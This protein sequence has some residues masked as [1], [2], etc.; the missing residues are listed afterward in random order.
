M[1]FERIKSIQHQ[2]SESETNAILCVLP[3]CSLQGPVT[4]QIRKG[5]FD[6]YEKLVRRS[7]KFKSLEFSVIAAS[8]E[9][10]IQLMSGNAPVLAEKVHRDTEWFEEI[11]SFFFV[12][13]SLYAQFR[14]ISDELDSGH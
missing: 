7:D 2:F 5:Q 11:K 13:N 10:S 6:A 8:V 4:P 9:Y 12:L 1:N 3:L 14:R